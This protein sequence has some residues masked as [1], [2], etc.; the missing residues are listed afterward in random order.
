MLRVCSW[1]GVLLPGPLRAV[2]PESTPP[3]A[4]GVKTRILSALAAVAAFLTLL[5][6]LDLSGI[7]DVLPPK[8]AT[9]LATALP[10]LAGVVHLINAL[11]DFLDDGKINGSFRSLLVLSLLAVLML[12]MSAC[13]VAFDPGTGRFG[14]Q[15]DPA[16][17]SA[18]I[19]RVNQR[20]NEKL[21]EE[22]PPI[23]VP[24]VPAK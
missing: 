1:I 18:I 14:V 16:S 19:E 2:D 3:H 24:V 9:G 15:T 6:G 4:D 10:L 23:A 13:T 5:G 8:V 11:G 12:G 20:L 17:V 21:A 22:V 7:I